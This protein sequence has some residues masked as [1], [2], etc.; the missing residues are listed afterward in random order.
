MRTVLVILALMTPLAAADKRD[1][2]KP[3]P[4]AAAKPAPKA[5]EIPAGALETQPGTFSYT[6]PQGKKWIYR[7]TPF[8][9]VRMEE[10]ADA[11]AGSGQPGPFG[12]ARTPAPDVVNV[13]VVDNGDTV[14]FERPGP[15]GLFKW[16]RKKGDLTVEERGWLERS[17]PAPPVAAKQN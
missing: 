4:A 17:H 5:I 16:D 10:K 2:G 3:A 7:Q 1:T 9:V 6:D 8:G 11:Q 12:A 15:F 14:H 13:K